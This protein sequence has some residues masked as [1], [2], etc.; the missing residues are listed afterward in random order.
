LMCAPLAQAAIIRPAGELRPATAGVLAETD[1]VDAGWVFRA[2]CAAAPGGLGRSERYDV[3][4][5]AQA[6]LIEAMQEAADRDRI[7]ACYA[8]GFRVLFDE[9]VPLLAEYEQRWG[10]RAWA[11]TALFMHVLSTHADSH[12]MRK[13]GGERAES[14]RNRAGFYWRSLSIAAAPQAMTPDLIAFDKELK[15][16]GE[17]PGTSADLVVGSLLAERLMNM[18]HI[19]VAVHGGL[20]R[21]GR[22]RREN[23]H[24]RMSFS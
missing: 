22:K 6:G 17:N 7:A 10:D 16:S 13:H 9:Y 5:P 8:S 1:I 18:S 19:D 2:I 20:E 4:E 15:M 11:A 12:I 21:S 3:T 23:P 14:V 24:E